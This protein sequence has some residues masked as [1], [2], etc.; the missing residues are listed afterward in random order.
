MD[1]VNS[2]RCLINFVHFANNLTRGI[3]TPCVLIARIKVL[4]IKS[5]AATA[6]IPGSATLRIYV[7]LVEKRH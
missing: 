5:S 7:N 4:G 2:I 6:G 1:A 3:K